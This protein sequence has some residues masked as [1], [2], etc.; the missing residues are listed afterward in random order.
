M[1]NQMV[2]LT[3]MLLLLAWLRAVHIFFETPLTSVMP[4]FTPLKELVKSCMQYMQVAH[5]GAFNGGTEKPLKLY[6]SSE[7]IHD[8]ERQKPKGLKKL[9]VKRDG[10]FYGTDLKGIKKSQ[11]YTPQF[12]AAIA[13]I[14][15]KCRK[16]QIPKLHDSSEERIP[17]KNKRK[18][19][20]VK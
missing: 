13:R 6:S 8:M 2:V 7:H 19:K 17:P 20:D 14:F 4:F 15:V 18:R 11:A 16:E 1:G 5:M 12:G 10:K 3:S 9:M